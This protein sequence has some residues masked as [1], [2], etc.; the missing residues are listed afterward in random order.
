[1]KRNKQD[2]GWN[3]MYRGCLLLCKEREKKAI[4]IYIY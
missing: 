4:Y 3:R 1:M 2:I